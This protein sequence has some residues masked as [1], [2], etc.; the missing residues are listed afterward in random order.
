VTL[1]PG[2]LSPSGFR[3]TVSSEDQYPSDDGNALRHLLGPR[4]CH[5]TSVYNVVSNVSQFAKEVDLVVRNR[6]S[7]ESKAAT[8]SHHQWRLV[9]IADHL[10]KTGK[11]RARQVATGIATNSLEFAISKQARN[12]SAPN[13]ELQGFPQGGNLSKRISRRRRPGTRQHSLGKRISAGASA[14]CGCTLA[15]VSPDRQV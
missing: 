14:Q 5:W 13:P 3:L 11:F 4:W 12:G 10:V 8:K 2:Q 9:E 1:T 6:H 15:V 7:I